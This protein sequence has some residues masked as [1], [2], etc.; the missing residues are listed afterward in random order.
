LFDISTG[1]IININTG[2]YFGIQIYIRVC[3]PYR[4]TK[5]ENSLG[6]YYGPMKKILAIAL[7]I[8]LLVGC[9]GTSDVIDITAT[10]VPLFADGQAIVLT[11]EAICDG[12][13]YDL[14]TQEGTPLP[15]SE[16]TEEYQGHGVWLV[17]LAVKNDYK[18]NVY[19]STGTVTTAGTYE[20]YM[21]YGTS[22]TA[23]RHIC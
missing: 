21:K 4:Y 10:D 22:R 15:L 20:T 16:F 8:L 1:L 23:T 2:R 14:A 5:G 13:S 17:Q 19:E 11:I 7:V 6:W 3:S 18:W 9:S 12:L